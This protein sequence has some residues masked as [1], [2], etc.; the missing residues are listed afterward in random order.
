MPWNLRQAAAENVVPALFSNLQRWKKRLIVNDS[1]L[2]SSIS[3]M[4]KG[5]PSP[6]D[7]ANQCLKH[8]VRFACLNPCFS[9]NLAKKRAKRPFPE[10]AQRDFRKDLYFP[11]CK[12]VFH[13]ALSLLHKIGLWF[14]LYIIY[15][16]AIGWLS[17]V[18][19]DILL[20]EAGNAALFFRR[21][22]IDRIIHEWL[23]HGDDAGG[24]DQAPF[25]GY[26]GWYWS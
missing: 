14:A 7:S 5:H 9:E 19:S 12:A 2:P 17:C 21:F 10:A 24:T 6:E 22:P 4:A 25:G 16:A 15:Y 1:V 18:L 20:P 13:W 26:C 8:P 23:R 3:S 11:E